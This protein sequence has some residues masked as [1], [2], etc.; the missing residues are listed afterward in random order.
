[1]NSDKNQNKLSRIYSPEKQTKTGK[2]RYRSKN[3]GTQ[4]ASKEESRTQI[5]FEKIM[6][7]NFP[8]PI[9]I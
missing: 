5:T 6:A 1:M 4:S 7:E 3:K 9:Q 8:L 2:K